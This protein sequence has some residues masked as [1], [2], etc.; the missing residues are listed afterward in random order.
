MTTLVDNVLGYQ[1][2]DSGDVQL[3]RTNVMLDAV[4]A[5]GVDGAV[6]LIGPGRA[7]FA[8]HA[9]PIEVEVDAARLATALAHLVADV[10][11]IDATGNARVGVVPT[12]GVGGYVDSTIV[13]AAALRGE[14]VR[15]EVRGPYTGGDP[16]HEPIVRGIVRAHGGVLQTHV[17]PGMSGS[18]YVLEVPIGGGAGAVPVADPSGV[19]GAAGPHTSVPGTAVEVASAAGPARAETGAEVGVGL[20][21]QAS[22]TRVGRR[23]ARRASGASVDSFLESGVAGAADAVPGADEARQGGGSEAAAPTGRRRRRAEESAAA[24]APG[25]LRGNCLPRPRRL[26]RAGRLPVTRGPG[27]VRGVGAGGPIRL[28]SPFRREPMPVPAPP[29][30]P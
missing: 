30:V 7:Q 15:I 28:R 13:V 11:G 5:A 25:A 9:P 27:P 3:T 6:E 18:A 23:R 4:V 14:S 17:V 20:P 10:A 2:L 26:R 8:V 24:G 19:V 1:L 21:E 22:G 12:S 16:V 29:R